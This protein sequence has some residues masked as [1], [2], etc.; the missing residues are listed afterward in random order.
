MSD[1]AALARRD[2]SRAALTTVEVEA[3]R[4]VAMLQRRVNL[5]IAGYLGLVAIVALVGGGNC[6][7]GLGAVVIGGCSLVFAAQLAFALH[8]EGAAAL[9]L[10]AMFVPFVNLA[11]LAILSAGATSRLRAAGIPVG[12]LGADPGSIHD[13]DA[14]D[15]AY[16]GPQLVGKDCVHCQRKIQMQSD[17]MLCKACQQPLHRACRKDHRVDAHRPEPRAVYR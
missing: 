7:F 3:L 4:R 6:L 13:R 12:L 17:G 1:P 16:E 10:V 2:E 15:V 14:G 8:G 9:S 5:T 11:T